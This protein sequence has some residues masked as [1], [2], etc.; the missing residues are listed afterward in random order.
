M[1][2]RH[3][4]HRPRPRR[5]G[6]PARARRN[7]PQR[8]RASTHTR[9]L[10]EH[11]D[12]YLNCLRPLAEGLAARRRARGAHA[13]VGVRAPSRAHCSSP[14][15]HRLASLPRPARRPA[16][17]AGSSSRMGARA[18]SPRRCSGS[19]VIGDPTF[20][21]ELELRVEALLES[22][23]VGH[24]WGPEDDLQ[25]SEG[26]PVPN[27]G[28]HPRRRLRDAAAAAHRRSLEVPAAGRRQ[29]DGRLDPRADPRG[30]GD[31]RGARRHEQPLRQ[32][33]EHW[34]MART[35]SPSTT[36]GRARTTTGSARSATSPSRSSERASS[37]TT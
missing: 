2:G 36:T 15:E 6:P 21:Q 13:G 27:E 22:R 34:A 23:G 1:A 33:F 3:A 12:A 7:H 16:A 19:S 10:D 20:Q 29:A 5:R 37:T 28:D 25:P 32:D 8:A 31:R 11:Y 35:A 17:R 4:R 24:Q 9:Q 26:A 30:R 18:S 14:L